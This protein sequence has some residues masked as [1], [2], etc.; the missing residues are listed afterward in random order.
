MTRKQFAAFT[1][2]VLAFLPSV[3]QGQFD[4][5]G[6]PKLD[7][8]ALPQQAR[9]KVEGDDVILECVIHQQVYETEIRQ[10]AETY[11]VEVDGKVE[12]GTVIKEVPITICRSVAVTEAHVLLAKYLRFWD[13]T[14]APVDSKKGLERLQTGD[15]VLFADRKV[16][17]YYLSVFKPETLLV[18]FTPRPVEMSV[19]KFDMDPSIPPVPAP[20]EAPPS[21]PAPVVPA[22]R[23]AEVPQ[24]AETDEEQPDA[25]G[26]DLP[27]ASMPGF[28]PVL[29]LATMKDKTISLRQYVKKT[30][31]K[32]AIVPKK[33]ED[34]QVAQ[35]PVSYELEY[36]QDLEYHY[37]V[38]A[39]QVRTA[40][41]KEVPETELA[42]L[43]AKGRTVLVSADGQPVSA[44]WL[45]IVRPEALVVVG[46]PPPT[47]TPALDSPA[48]P[49]T[50]PAPAPAPTPIPVPRS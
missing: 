41:G 44:N 1:I 8:L 28:P 19:P 16:P 17:S 45:K 12:T 11:R 30:T 40:D 27:P 26:A 7:P 42:K 14:G 29:K 47:L 21:D 43:L 49:E 5:G 2:L 48:P 50:A 33:M 38:A 20:A 13:M 4:Y 3:T 32:S 23:T 36:V 24:A 37:P 9:A 10:F 25:T 35:V 46:P 31:T 22:P 18:Q 15:T 39:L 6:E 34:G